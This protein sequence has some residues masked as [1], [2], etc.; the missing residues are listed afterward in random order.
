MSRETRDASDRAEHRDAARD[1]ELILAAAR[2]A[3]EIADSAVSGAADDFP[4]YRILGEASRGGQGVVYHALQNSTGRQVAIKVLL[5]GADAAEPLRRR[6]EREIQLVAQFRHPNIVTVFDSGLTRDGRRFCVMDFIRGEPLD[7][8]ARDSQLSPREIAALLATTCRAVDHAHQRGVV[9]RDLKPS[10][11]LVEADR[12]PRVLD[13]GLAKPPAESDATAVSLSGQVMG[14]LAYMSPEQAAG[15][16][17]RID[18]RS[19]VYALGVIAYRLL[20]GVF[21]YNVAGNAHEVLQHI[22]ND[23]PTPPSRVRRSSSLGAADA[24]QTIRLPEGSRSSSAGMRNV[25]AA[26]SDRQSP[27]IPRELDGIVL[28]CLRKDP[29]ARY[30][31][32]GALAGDLERYLRGE[33]VAARRGQLGYAVRKSLAR[34]RVRWLGAA[35]LLAIGATG[36]GWWW[37]ALRMGRIAA[38]VE[39]SLTEASRLLGERQHLERAAS[40][41]DA[42]ATVA[43]K[44]AP[45]QSMRGLVSAA[46]AVEAP[47][48][49]RPRWV[50][51]SLTAFE[52][53]HQLAG[54]RGFLTNDTTGDLGTSPALY[55]ALDLA[56]L[57]GRDELA[58]RLLA[59][60]GAPA[61]EAQDASPTWPQPIYRLDRDPLLAPTPTRDTPDTARLAAD[62]SAS[63]VRVLPTRRGSLHPGDPPS[64]DYYVVELLFDPL[65]VANQALEVVA[66]PSVVESCEPD[67]DRREWTIRLR[68]GLRWHDDE[69]LDARDVEFSW[70]G[71]PPS[72]RDNVLL[73]SVA[74][75]D[76]RTVVFRLAARCA[77]PLREMATFPILPRHLLDAEQGGGDFQKSPIGNG[78]YRISQQDE[79]RVVL[80]RWDGYRGRKP[81][82]A[83][84][85]FEYVPVQT[86][87]NELLAAGQADEAELNANQFRWDVNGPTFAQVR[88]FAVPRS[89][90]DY[91]AWNTREPP[92]DDVRV[93]RALAAAVNLSALREQRFG[94]LFTEFDGI[95]AGAPW[96]RGDA[97]TSTPAGD[98]DM[99]RAAAMLDEAG[100]RRDADGLRKRDGEPLRVRLS[101]PREARSFYPV[102]AELKQAWAALGVQVDIELTPFS[103][104]HE[105]IDAREF[106]AYAGSLI[107]APTPTEEWTRWGSDGPR[108][109][110]GI[111]DPRIDALFARA[112]K[113]TDL[114]T[115][116]AA[117]REIEA[118]I[119]DAQ[120]CLFLWRKPALW[121]FSKRIRGLEF[122]PRGPV[123]FYPGARAWWV[124]K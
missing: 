71:L 89:Q 59:S 37:Q 36:A 87:R 41:L 113:A 84:V 77:A 79:Q 57:D 23:E 70:H 69:P 6:F 101:V 18:T 67:S 25:F 95:W 81:H 122:S 116:S 98:F 21:P 76:A 53:A 42:A 82:I 75:R 5:E 14:T 43:P 9:H 50:E 32:A 2:E 92:L 88:K 4:G 44:S 110:T 65:F 72:S 49:E 38:A 46:R 118:R 111:S 35:A 55:S 109:I 33:A 51:A 97:P 1:N 12:T 105:R 114:A 26:R 78:P 16:T 48:D 39:R 47:L 102:A 93:R 28:M 80:E 7:R 63:I 86:R 22:L 123:G 20:T 83:R 3:R 91:I 96:A 60:A 90:Y 11:I 104:L 103:E 68:D 112:R 100:Y 27:R 64:Y 74:A 107:V 54:G 85:V 106:D 66:N 121:A 56:V 61:V 13:F 8:F 115:E 34:H 45:L 73:E 117:C 62:E 124:A 119:L 19:D 108:N 58:R 15:Q 120:P 10:N 29:R 99:P 52:M 30:P 40:L 94:G 24:E 31:T 17:D